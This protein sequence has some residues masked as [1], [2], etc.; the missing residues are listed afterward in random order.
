MLRLAEVVEQLPSGFDSLRAEA[1]AEGRRFLERLANDWASGTMQ[2]DHAGEALF[3]AHIDD[4]LAAV[5]GLTIDPHVAGALRMRR[6]Y[7][8]AQFRR[9][10]VGRALAEVLLERA[11]WLNRPVTVNAAVGSVPF[12]EALGFVADARE[13][14]THILPT[15]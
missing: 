8:R 12:W 14:H 6:F 11:R 5:G 10:G 1:R 15:R 13:G 3:A 7:V 9:N 2:F 4:V